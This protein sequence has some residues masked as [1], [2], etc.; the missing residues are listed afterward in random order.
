MFTFGREVT[1]GDI[2]SADE[3]DFERF[4]RSMKTWFE[5]TYSPTADDAKRIINRALMQWCGF[6]LNDR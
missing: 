3:E 6:S 1:G 2:K 4:A 5:L